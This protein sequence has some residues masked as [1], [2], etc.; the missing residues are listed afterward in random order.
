MKNF[1]I[2]LDLI[3][4]LMSISDNLVEKEE[5]G[6]SNKGVKTIIKTFLNR[7]FK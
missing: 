4:K 2:V 5:N 7:I 6:M 1:K 3:N